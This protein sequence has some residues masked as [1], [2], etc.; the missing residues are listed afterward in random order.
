MVYCRFFFLLSTI[1]FIGNSCSTKKKSSIFGE[2]QSK[3]YSFFE[4]IPLIIKNKTYVLHSKI[5]LNSDSTYIFITCGTEMKG[6][7]HVSNDSLILICKENKFINDSLNKIRKA[8]C[9][10]KPVKM[11][12]D[13]EKNELREDLNLNGKK[14]QNYF[15][16]K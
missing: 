3:R 9:G 14:V 5:I 11:F 15:S 7:W 8:S 12:L 13:F 2:Y 10:E 6:I 1:I 4:R 16:K